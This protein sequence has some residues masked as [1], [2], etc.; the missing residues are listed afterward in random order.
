M[1]A[2]SR[3]LIEL[4]FGW[5]V[6][7]AGLVLVAWVVWSLTWPFEIFEAKPGSWTVQNPGKHVRRGEAIVVYLDYCVHE[8]LS[9]HMDMLIE[10]DKRLMLLETTTPAAT[11][12]C[13]KVVLPIT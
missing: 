1:K 12:G 6:I 8:R 4:M 5:G 13:H 11:L 2:A 7:G 9:P 3:S 10:Q